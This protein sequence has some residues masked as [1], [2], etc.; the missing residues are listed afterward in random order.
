MSQ[1]HPL[2]ALAE[3]PNGRVRRAD[4]YDC[5]LP[6]VLACDAEPV[7]ERQT[8]APV[9]QAPRPGTQYRRLGDELSYTPETNLLDY[10]VRHMPRT[11]RDLFRGL[12]IDEHGLAVPVGYEY[13]SL[14]VMLLAFPSNPVVAAAADSR[15]YNGGETVAW[16]KPALPARWANIVL[17]GSGGG[18]GGGARVTTSGNQAAGGGGGGGGGYI[19]RQLVLLSSLSN[20][21]VVVG[22]N[23]AGGVAQSTAN[24]NGNAGGDGVNTTFAGLTAAKGL[25]GGGGT[26]GA[27]AQT[28]ASG[29]GGAGDVAG[30]AGGTGRSGATVG[31]NGTAGATN[32]AGAGGAGGGGATADTAQANGGAGGN[33]FSSGAG[34]GSAGAAG[35]TAGGIGTSPSAGGGGGGGCDASNTAG[36]AG[37]NAGYTQMGGGGG[38]GGGRARTSAT[39]TGNG[40]AGGLGGNGFASVISF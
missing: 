25:G 5:L 23:P 27:G 18:G 26:Q 24:T 38:G 7:A 12:K 22:S 6:S 10:T 15:N 39:T 1:R 40:A 9:S 28:G 29:A 8:L 30:K 31:D 16:V 32:P 13:L 17:I 11:Y 36:G 2:L 34:G 19:G 21:N 20:G 3:L 14:F 37:G 35:G 33:A 4:L